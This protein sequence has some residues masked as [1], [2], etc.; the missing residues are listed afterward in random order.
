MLGSDCPV[1]QYHSA[2]LQAKV[3]LRNEYVWQ[4]GEQMYIRLVEDSLG[5]ISKSF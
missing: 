3:I 2:I 1:T 5:K 4:L